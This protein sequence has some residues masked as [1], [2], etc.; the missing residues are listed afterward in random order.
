MSDEKTRNALRR[1]H[2]KIAENIDP[3]VEVEIINF[4][5]GKKR[6]L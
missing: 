2:R 4:S 6:K 3:N 5:K 1:L